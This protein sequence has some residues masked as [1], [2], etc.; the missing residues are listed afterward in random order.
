MRL[1]LAENVRVLRRRNGMSQ[2][3]LA[4][5]A[6][7][8]R[9]HVNRIEGARCAVALD[10]VATIAEVLK[11]PPGKLLEQVESPT[12]NI[13]R[14]VMVAGNIRRVRRARVMSVPVLAR[15]AKIPRGLLI[16][17]ESANCEVSNETLAAL[18]GALDVEP[19]DLLSEDVVLA[20]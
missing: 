17:I 16:K 7:L 10:T 9:E 12:D 18:A 6:Q 15:K 19:A 4:S 5:A 11:V 14:R 1:N 20:H 2:T 13:Q 3:A 8:C